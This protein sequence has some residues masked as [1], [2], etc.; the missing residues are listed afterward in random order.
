[1]VN[2]HETKTFAYTTDVLTPDGG[3][4]DLEDLATHAELIGSQCTVTSVSIPQDVRLSL[5]RGATK[6]QVLVE[7]GSLPSGTKLEGVLSVVTARP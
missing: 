7:G 1:M 6:A 3:L 2:I 4:V 5:V